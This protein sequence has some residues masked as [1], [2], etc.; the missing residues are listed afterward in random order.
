MV[1][2]DWIPEERGRG[3]GRGLDLGEGR[4]S[5]GPAL[6][7]G[8]RLPTPSGSAHSGKRGAQGQVH[9]RPRPQPGS[10]RV[11]WSPP[12]LS[13]RS[14]V[15]V[16]PPRFGCRCG[17]ERRAGKHSQR[18]WLPASARV[19]AHEAPDPAFLPGSRDTRRRR[20]RR[21]LRRARAQGRQVA[22][23]RSP[24]VT[25][26]THRIGLTRVRIPTAACGTVS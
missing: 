2:T 6:G 26:P 9:S 3:T 24:R 4:G 20:R 16:G 14:A 12:W 17:A 15:P 11:T 25:F 23:E 7:E 19:S 22:A 21:R 1:A 10:K 5:T 8:A 13:S 18:P